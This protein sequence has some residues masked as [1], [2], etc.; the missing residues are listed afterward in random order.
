MLKVV[1]DIVVVNHPF[2]QN[3]NQQIK[4][5]QEPHSFIHGVVDCCK[6]VHILLF[7]GVGFGLMYLPSIVIVNFYFLR[8]RALATGIAVC[9]SGEAKVHPPLKKP[10]FGGGRNKLFATNSF[11]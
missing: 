8:R 4:H 10:P 5:I 7:A 9:G 3:R 11:A 6:I 1:V 2:T